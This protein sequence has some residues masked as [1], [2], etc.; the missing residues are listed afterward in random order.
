MID[1]NEGLTKTYN[2]FHARGENAADIARLRTLHAEMDAAVL[3]AYGWDDLADRAAPEFIEQD[4]DEG[5]T[6]KTRL[7]W[8]AEFKDEV[9]ARLLAL[10]AER[11]AAERVGRPDRRC[12]TTKKKL[13]RSTPDDNRSSPQSR[14][15]PTRSA[16]GSS[17]CSVAILL[18][19]IR[20]TLTSISERL[21]DNPSRWYLAGFL[22]PA[23]DGA[24]EEAEVIEDVGDPLFGEDEGADPEVG[25]GRAADDTPD[26]EPSARKSRAPS[27]CGLT[28]MIDASVREIE[29]TLSW[30]DYVTL[31]PLPDEVFLDEKAQ[32]DP[33][34]R[35][36]QWQ[37]MPGKETCLWPC[38][39]TVAANE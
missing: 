25:G 5:K 21:T 19:Q 34:Y 6:P 11:A 12:P 36:V 35:N 37:R 4:A 13:K 27:S 15:V 3:R 38:P 18:D 14:Q 1:R 7:D 33:A 9:L 17:M 16:G 28:V 23:P 20:Q 30:G 10:N 32:F 39:R 8:P 31:P 24:G 22:A 26:D 29:V 2:R